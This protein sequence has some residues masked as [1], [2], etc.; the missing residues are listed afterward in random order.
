MYLTDFISI[1]SERYWITADLRT[2]KTLV[3][4]VSNGSLERFIRNV[5]TMPD[6]RA[7]VSKKEMSA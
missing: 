2:V 4:Q 3:E 5:L 6:P 7:E 1:R